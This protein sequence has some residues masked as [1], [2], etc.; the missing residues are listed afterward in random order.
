MAC[1]FMVVLSYLSVQKSMSSVTM[2]IL[3]SKIEFGLLS[4]VNKAKHI[5]FDKSYITTRV[6]T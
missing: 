2:T 4:I 5:N 3:M 1:Q 6:Q